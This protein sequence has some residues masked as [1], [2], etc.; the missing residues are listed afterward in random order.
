MPEKMEEAGDDE[1]R[2]AGIIN[3]LSNRLHKDKCF[4]ASSDRVKAG[5]AT[6]SALVARRGQKLSQPYSATG[7]FF[8]HWFILSGVGQLFQ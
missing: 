4:I 1:N 7:T 3:Y 5:R 2:A 6:T 8:A